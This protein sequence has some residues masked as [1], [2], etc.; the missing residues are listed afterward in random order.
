MLSDKQMK[1]RGYSAAFRHAFDMLKKYGD[2]TDESAW[3]DLDEYVYGNLD[4]DA[5]FYKEYPG[6]EL[7]AKHLNCAVLHEI[8]RRQGK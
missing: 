6:I 7:F 1:E 8:A 3:T 4:A 5:A 2:R